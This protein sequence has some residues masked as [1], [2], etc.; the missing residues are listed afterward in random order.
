[1]HER[2]RALHVL[3]REITKIRADL[4]AD[5]TVDAGVGDGAFPFGQKRVLRGE[6]VELP[7]FERVGLGVFYAGLDL[8]FVAGH[9]RPGR[10]QRRTI[11]RTKVA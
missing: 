9:P 11:V 8:A 5:R 7:P 6:A 10:Q 4:L 2:Q 3:V 1:M